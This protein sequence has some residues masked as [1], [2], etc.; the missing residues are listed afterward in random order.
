M[1]NYDGDRVKEWAGNSQWR[2]WR[3]DYARFRKC[4]YCAWGSE[5]FWALTIYRAQRGVMK[6]HPKVLWFP[7]KLGLAITRKLFT[8]VTHISLPPEAEI[9]P[10]LVIP[11]VGTIQVSPWAR[12]GADCSIHHVCTIGAGSR[13]GAA[14]IGD[15][16]TIG[17]HTCILGPVKIGSGATIA[18]GA[19]VLS[20]VPANTMAVGIQTS[21]MVP[22]QKWSRARRE[23]SA[24]QPCQVG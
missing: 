1:R 10:G 5:G 20:D 3:A 15:H 6:R 24:A 11:H 16:V 14:E 22:V 9:G 21:R 4:G 18:A 19:V 7:V 17:C 12:I 23:A 13:P 2:A 8:M